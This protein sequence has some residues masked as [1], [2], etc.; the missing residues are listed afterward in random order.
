MKTYDLMQQVNARGTFLVSK[1]CLPYLRRSR[2]ARILTLSP[3]LNL[4]AKWF[5]NNCAYS[6]AKYGM[7]LCVLGM[8]EEFRRHQIAVNALWPQT[9]IATAAVQ[10][11]LGGAAAVSRCRKPQITAD[12]AYAIL[13]QPATVTGEFFID[14]AALRCFDGVTDFSK[15]KVTAELDEKDLMPDFF[16]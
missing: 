5:K 9:A 13:C 7:S 3:P 16:L 15:Y 2:H 10:F 6:I 12:A 11:K 8:S 1:T 14:E 4:Q